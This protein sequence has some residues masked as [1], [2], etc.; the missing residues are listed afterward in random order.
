MSERTAILRRRKLVLGSVALLACF[1]VLDGVLHFVNRALRSAVIVAGEDGTP[2]SSDL[3]TLVAFFRGVPGQAGG[4]VGG[5]AAKIT[6][7]RHNTLCTRLEVR[8]GD[9]CPRPPRE[10]VRVLLLDGPDRGSVL[11]V[12]G[13]NVIPRHP[14][15]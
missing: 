12:C 4:V 6:V 9:V 5:G 2:V 7:I 14:L 3:P 11:W 10:A 15:P 1:A 13:S 8:A